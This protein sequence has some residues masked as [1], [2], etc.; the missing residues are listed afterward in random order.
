[1]YEYDD[2]EALDVTKLRYVLYA[3]KSTVDETRQV[4]SIPDQIA[5]CEFLSTRLGIKVVAILKETQ[6]AKKP[7]QRP[8]F[9]KMLADI[10]QGKYDGILSWHPD[11]LARNMREGGEIIDMIDEDYIKD[12]KFVT[13]HFTPDANGKMLLGMAFVL[14]KQYSDDLSQ[15]VS[16]G[17]RRGFAEGKSSGT[18]KPGY[19]RT[20]GGL[21][22]PDGKNYELLADAFQMRLGGTG[23]REI[24][25]YMNKSGYGRK[26]KGTKAKRAGQ[27]VLMDFRRLSDILGD[28]FYYGVLMQAGKT[29]DLRNVPGYNFTPAV[30]EADWQA[31]QALTKGGKRNKLKPK[32]NATYYPLRGMV[33]CSFCQHNMYA[34]ASKGH[35]KR[36]LYYTCQNQECER[37]PRAIRG[38]E[39]FNFVYE[40]LQD[41]LYLTEDDYI[42]YRSNLHGI[43]ERK[44]ET[45]RVQLH[46]REGALKSINRNIDERSLGMVKLDK[47]SRVWQVNEA[48]ITRLEVQAEDL[49]SDIARIKKDLTES[50]GQNMSIDQFLNLSQLAGSKLEAASVEAKDRICQRIFLNFVV[51]TEKVVDFQ[52]KEPFATLLKTRKILNGRGE[53]TRTFDLA[54]PN[55]AR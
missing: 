11:R 27:T 35:K 3:R 9:T 37:K 50:E 14:S 16:R 44:R 13:H 18:P 36:Y 42:K 20:D 2:P 41:G 38:K 48:E 31:V 29:V 30:T 53:R 8:V 40:F 10:R 39:I 24:A 19:N 28:P 15:K 6:S 32:P 55:R 54:V 17:I 43:S 33:Q 51:D 23:Y 21:Y 45:L 47:G 4:R 7:N 34:G 25:D 1:M 5:D 26:I 22:E 46:Q 12:L 52:M 49:Q